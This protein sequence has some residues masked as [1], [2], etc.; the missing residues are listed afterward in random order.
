MDPNRSIA[1]RFPDDVVDFPSIP[2]PFRSFMDL[3]RRFHE[4]DGGEND[5]VIVTMVR[6]RP[7]QERN[8]HVSAPSPTKKV[9]DCSNTVRFLMEMVALMSKTVPLRPV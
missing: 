8:R 2:V 1:D 5:R 7:V 3:D 4:P 6:F 9:V